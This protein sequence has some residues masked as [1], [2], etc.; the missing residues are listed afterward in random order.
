MGDK[1]KGLFKGRAKCAPVCFSLELGKKR[2]LSSET[3]VL[4]ETSE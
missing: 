3:T 2:P 4:R 1:R